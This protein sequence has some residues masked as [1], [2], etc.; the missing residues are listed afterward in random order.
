M[1]SAI[2]RHQ[3]YEK[4]TAEVSEEKWS[5]RKEERYEGVAPGSHERKVSQE[6]EI[7]HAKMLL[8]D[9]IKQGWGSTMVLAIEWPLIT[10]IRAVV[11]EEG[12]KT[13]RSGFQRKWEAEAWM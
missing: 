4:G 12:L 13:P 11:M 8:T 6:R 1:N 10:L 9:Q 3:E 7:G 5:C 2:F